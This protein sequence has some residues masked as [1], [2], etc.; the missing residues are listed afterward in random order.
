MAQQLKVL[1][2]KCDYLSSIPGTNTVGRINSFKLFSNLYNIL[3]LLS[4][5]SASLSVS[6]THT[7]QSFTT[8]TRRNEWYTVAQSSIWK[9]SGCVSITIY[10]S[11]HGLGVAPGHCLAIG[12]S[13]FC[14]A[15]GSHGINTVSS[16]WNGL[17]L[18]ID[19]WNWHAGDKERIPCETA[20]FP[21]ML[22]AMG[23]N[24]HQPAAAIGCFSV[25]TDFRNSLTW[26]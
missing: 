23:W 19:A 9:Q 17:W 26:G 3:W 13:Q 25:L 21:R 24:V 16:G 22:L 11:T 18:C 2:T 15:L 14:S 8:V 5:L 10:A 1:A 7:S 4:F 6:Y 20:H 12:M